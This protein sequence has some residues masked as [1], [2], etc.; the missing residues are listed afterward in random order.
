M[1]LWGEL[2]IPYHWRAWCPASLDLSIQ[3]NEW[4]LHLV[5]QWIL[6][7]KCANHRYCLKHVAFHSA[8]SFIKLSDLHS[9]QTQTSEVRWAACFGDHWACLHKKLP[10]GHETGNQKKASN[11]RISQLNQ[12][13]SYK[14]HSNFKPTWIFFEE[15]VCVLQ[16]M[17][18]TKLK[19]LDVGTGAPQQRQ[20]V[21]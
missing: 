1:A 19:N 14:P 2:T 4:R 20:E 5:K 21:Y 9:T 16:M 6:S 11:G 3:R 7:S 15:F 13:W 10:R 18:I 17:L 8:D 12:Y